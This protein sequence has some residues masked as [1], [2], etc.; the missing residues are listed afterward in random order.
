MLSSDTPAPLTAQ[1]LSLLHTRINSWY[2]ECARNLPW[3]TG[4]NTPWEVMVSEFMLQ[5]TPV[6]RVLPVWEQWLER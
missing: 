5:Q 1:E 2:L 3:R 4:S 6:K